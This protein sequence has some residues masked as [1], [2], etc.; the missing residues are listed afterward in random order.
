MDAGP[1]DAANVLGAAFVRDEGAR[2]A[3]E[4]EVDAATLQSVEAQLD[5]LRPALESFFQVRL[6]DREG[7]SLLRYLPGGFYGPHRDRADVPV[8]PGAARR[9]IALVLFLNSSREADAAA[10]LDGGMLRL[11]ADDGSAT[12]IHPREGALAAFPAD[13]LHEVTTVRDGV[14]DV[15]VD[16][17]YGAP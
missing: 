14:R 4:I 12:D 13:A 16:W 15:V 7:A 1:G 11:F 8:W 3:L 17:F 2:R 9:R 10:D 6:G 5:S